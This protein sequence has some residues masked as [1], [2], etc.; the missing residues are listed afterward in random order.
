MSNLHLHNEQ[1][2]LR[3]L[4]NRNEPLFKL[5]TDGEHGLALPA[6][7]VSLTDATI[8]SLYKQ[9]E[10]NLATADAVL[11]DNMLKAVAARLPNGRRLLEVCRLNVQQTPQTFAQLHHLYQP[12]YVIG[13]GIRRTD[14]ALNVQVNLYETFGLMDTQMFFAEQLSLYHSDKERKNRMWKGLQQLFGIAP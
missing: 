6:P 7:T 1:A 11:L 8:V 3:W 4:F 10:P 14:I 9:T 5:P 12:Q 13:F 2:N